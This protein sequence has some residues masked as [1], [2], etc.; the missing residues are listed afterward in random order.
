[1]HTHTHALAETLSSLSLLCVS[2]GTAVWTWWMHLMFL[3][4]RGRS[5]EHGK[6]TGKISQKC[7]RG[8]QPE[9]F[10]KSEEIHQPHTIIGLHC[11]VLPG[12]QPI[13]LLI[14]R[15]VKWLCTLMLPVHM[16]KVLYLSIKKKVQSSNRIFEW[17]LLILIWKFS[18]YLTCDTI[19]LDICIWYCR[20]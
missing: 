16:F 19:D 9:M 12:V 13:I 5:C 4:V 18:C 7:Q 14:Q 11:P 3:S 1:M 6:D 15:V 17:Q 2:C 10:T 20:H 8:Y